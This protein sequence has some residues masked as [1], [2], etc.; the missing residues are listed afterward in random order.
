MPRR[1]SKPDRLLAL[2]EN[3]VVVAVPRRQPRK[4]KRLLAAKR[5]RRFPTPV[6]MRRPAPPGDSIM[7]FRRLLLAALRVWE[8]KNGI[9]DYNDPI[10]D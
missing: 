3:L 6:E 9:H 4:R 8:L 2:D 1:V 5:T 7:R 10:L